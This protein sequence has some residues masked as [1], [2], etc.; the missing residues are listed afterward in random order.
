MTS[1]ALVGNQ[2]TIEGLEAVLLEG[3]LSKLNAEQRV[4]YYQRVCASVGLNPLTQPFE[5]LTLQG[6][7]ILYARRACTDQLRQIH[8]VSVRITARERVDGI[9]VVTAQATLADGRTDESIGAVPTDGLKGE[10]LSNALMKA[11]TKAK[12]RVTLAICG[13]SMMDE[14]EVES[15]ERRDVKPANVRKTLDDVA[16]TPADAYDEET[17]EVVCSKQTP[18]P[19]KVDEYGITIPTSKCPVVMKAGPNKGKAWTELT[20]P[21]IEFMYKDVEHMTSVQRD[22]AE[23]L[24]MKHGARKELEAA[25]AAEKGEP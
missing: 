17:G 11:E 22:W 18:E 6:K 15:I 13:L 10:A 1:L 23:Y 24:L 20:R 9:Y 4:Q 12:R 3:N 14:T 19:V 21:V 2:P 25:E 16:S 5:Y 7:T 8:K